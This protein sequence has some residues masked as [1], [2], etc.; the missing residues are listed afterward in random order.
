MFVQTLPVVVDLDPTLDAATIARTLRSNLH[1]SMKHSA[2]SFADICHDLGQKMGATLVFQKGMDFSI[3]IDG[4]LC[5]CSVIKRPSVKSD[6]TI[7]VY[8]NGN[9]YDLV[10]EVSSAL[11]DKE[12]IARFLHTMT[13][14]IGQ[15]MDNSKVPLTQIPLVTATEEAELLSMSKGEQLAYDHSKT[16]VDLFTDQARRT[17]DN[18]CVVFKDKRYT[19]QEVDQLTDRLAVLLQQKYGVCP[20]TAVV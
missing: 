6:A 14:V 5:H 12:A 8:P 18:I 17:P 2:Y 3:A 16:L 13:T 11:M 7:F 1:E 9:C 19:Y 20:E 4:E 15:L 10:L